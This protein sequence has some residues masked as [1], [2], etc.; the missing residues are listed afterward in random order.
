MSGGCVCRPAVR[1]V[2]SKMEESLYHPP[3][4][5]PARERAAV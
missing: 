1:E 3:V 4:Q 5:E 2:K